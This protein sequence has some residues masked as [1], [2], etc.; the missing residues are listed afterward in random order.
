MSFYQ[1]HLVSL[2]YLTAYG[3]LINPQSWSQLLKA[4]I[5]V[6]LVYNREHLIDS[7]AKV[8]LHLYF[9][10][11]LVATIS[12]SL[13]RSIGPLAAGYLDAILPIDQL[14]TILAPLSFILIANLSA[15]VKILSCRRNFRIAAAN[16]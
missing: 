14:T 12:L 3:H 9:Q 15:V 5:A 1:F 16:D 10:L 13:N 8:A 7:R 11:S 4:F 2:R 6:L